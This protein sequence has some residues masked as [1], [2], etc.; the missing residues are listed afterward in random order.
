MVALLLLLPL[1]LDL[2]IAIVARLHGRLETA[3]TRIAIAE[4]RSPKTRTRSI[5]IAATGAIAVFG[6]VAIQGAHA[7][8]QRGLDRLVYQLSVTTDVW[9]VPPGAQ[10]LLATAPF[11][12][13]AA[14]TL[15]RLPGV[16]S[17]G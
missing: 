11:K 6:S 1:L 13:T 5:A 17:V 3:S 9:V 14:A 16:Q 4:L 8:L 12:D 10:S 7:N 2:I 15:E